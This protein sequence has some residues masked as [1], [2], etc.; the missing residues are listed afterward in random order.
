MDEHESYFQ[1]SFNA[2][3]ILLFGP[4]IATSGV[5][6]LGILEVDNEAEA[7]R[8]AE[9]DP[10]VQAGLNKYELHPMRVSAARSKD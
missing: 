3:R 9:A 7:R 10:S 5:F 1:K 4:V 8:F 2:G 6:G